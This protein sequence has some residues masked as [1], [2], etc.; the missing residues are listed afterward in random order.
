MCFISLLSLSFPSEPI[1]QG[2]TN[3]TLLR[4]LLWSIK[5]HIG[6]LP[7]LQVGPGQK[8]LSIHH[9]CK[10]N[11]QERFIIMVIILSFITCYCSCTHLLEVSLKKVFLCL[12][13]G[14][15]FSSLWWRLMSPRCRCCCR[16][17]QRCACVLLHTPLATVLCGFPVKQ[18]SLTW[19]LT[20]FKTVEA[21]WDLI[22]IV[23]TF[24]VIPF[25]SPIFLL[26]GERRGR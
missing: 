5:H 4:W 24:P 7:S 22:T 6:M 3:I 21:T 19:W 23:N 25:F 15:G 10:W 20:R 14:G 11:M 1:P 9:N 8:Y 18:P 16:C 2:F 12:K 17:Y 13:S 26:H